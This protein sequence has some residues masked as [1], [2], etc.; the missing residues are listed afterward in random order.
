MS[1]LFVTLEVEQHVGIISLNRAAKHN[2]MNDEMQAQFG[3]CIHQAAADREIRCVLIRP[4]GKSFCAGRDISVLGKRQHGESDFEFVRNTQSDR[5]ATLDCPKPIIA[6]VRGAAI[7]GG[8]E[9]A[10]SADMRVLSRTARFSLPEI[11]YGLLPDTGGHML[12]TQLMGP[13]RAKYYI[14]TGD[15]IEAEEAYRL[16]LGEWLVDDAA[17]DDFALSLAR[18]IATGPPQALAMAKQLIDRA[19]GADL[20]A[21]MREELLA[22]SALFRTDDYAEARAALREQRRPSYSGT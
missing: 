15:V 4:S 3:D 12:L 11:K 2:A 13:A 22:Q 7:G 10:L 9:I 8:C 17:L 1:E 21:G 16:G 20:R 18:R 6:A 5:L 14:M 19:W